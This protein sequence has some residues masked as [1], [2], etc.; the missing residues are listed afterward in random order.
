[1]ATLV[2]LNV[3]GQGDLNGHGCEQRA[4]LVCQFDS[5]RHWAEHPGRDDLRP[6]NFGENG[7]GDDEVCVGDRYRIGNAVFEVTQPRVTCYRVG[8]RLRHVKGPCQT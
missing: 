2:S 8:L 3:D 7:L 5:Y 1:M 4:V 6:G